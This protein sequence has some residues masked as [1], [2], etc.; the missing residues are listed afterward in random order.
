[1]RCAIIYLQAFDDM[2]NISTMSPTQ[3]VYHEKSNESQ[4]IALILRT[5]PLSGRQGSC[6][7]VAEALWGPVHSRGMFEHCIDHEDILIV[8]S[9]IFLIGIFLL[10]LFKSISTRGLGRLNCSSS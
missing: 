1:M 2:H 7:G 9:A 5:L 3:R 6:G 8:P 4:L 10:A